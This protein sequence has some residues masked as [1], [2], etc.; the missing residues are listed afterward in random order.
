MILAFVAQ[1]SNA[2]SEKRE[3]LV[4]DLRAENAELRSGVN[5]KSANDE[6]QAAAVDRLQRELLSLQQET[7][8]REAR[9]AEAEMERRKLE[10]LKTE[11]EM[12]NEDLRRKLV[13][14]END[15]FFVSI[16]RKSF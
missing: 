10:Y 3:K 1:S 2:E 4:A 12:E 7:E 9:E 5:E 15:G 16:I 11:A 14:C 8:E 6:V 13:G